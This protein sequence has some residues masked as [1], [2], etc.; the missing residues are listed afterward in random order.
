MFTK[1]LTIQTMKY[2]FCYIKPNIDKHQAQKYI[3][4]NAKHHTIHRVL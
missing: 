2:K 3:Y 1:L 4:L